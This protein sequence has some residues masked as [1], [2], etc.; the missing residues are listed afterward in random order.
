MKYLLALLA[1]AT[2]VGAVAP[3]ASAAV[4]VYR[5]AHYAY[6]YHG[7]YYHGRHCH[8]YAGRS[9]CRYY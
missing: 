6:R 7:R 8:W 9:V 5:G 4:Y 3:P 1:A 2:L